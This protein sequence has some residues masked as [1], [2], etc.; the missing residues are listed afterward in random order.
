MATIVL[1]HGV[2]GFGDLTGGFSPV[3]YFNGV[4]AHL[5]RQGHTVFTPS[6]NPIGCVEVRGEQLAAAIVRALD[7]PPKIHIIAHSMGGLD[8]RFALAH[9]RDFADRVATL[10]TIGTPHRGSP[11]ADALVSGTGPILAHIPA[12]LIRQLERNAGALHDLTTE[13][14]SRF[15]DSTPDSRGVRYVD[16]AGDASKGGHELFLFQ[17]AAVIGRFTGGAIN[18][19]VVA[20]SSA[21]RAGHE[22]LADWPVDHAGEVGW[23][24]DTPLPVEFELP[25]VSP[26]PH[27]ARYDAIVAA[28]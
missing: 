6:V 21:V 10:V 26:P 19:G 22:S 18:D 16:I 20:R 5:R 13:A 11:V 2:L 12:F 14:G 3:N 8:A 17:L 1:A 27:F 15:D 9:V 23:S 24:F 4:A 28:L 7:G 25:L